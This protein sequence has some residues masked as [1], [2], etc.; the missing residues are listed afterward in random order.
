MAI[1]LRILERIEFGS[2][3]VVY[4]DGQRLLKGSKPGPEAIL[5]VNR[6]NPSQQKKT[7]S[8]HCHLLCCQAVLMIPMAVAKAAL[9]VFSPIVAF[10]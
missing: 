3:L 6:Q 7:I 2:L 5:R 9:Q 10:I 8:P 1:V 4:R